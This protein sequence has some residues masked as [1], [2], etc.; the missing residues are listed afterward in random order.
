ML[1]FKLYSWRGQDI[2]GGKTLTAEGVFAI[3]E[4]K[5]VEAA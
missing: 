4:V 2:L 5:K 3:I 1:F